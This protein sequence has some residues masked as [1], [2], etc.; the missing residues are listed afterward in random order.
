MIKEKKK[1][2]YSIKLI[3][4]RFCYKIFYFNYILNKTINNTS[5]FFFFFIF[6]FFFFIFFFIK[7][8]FFFFFKF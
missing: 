2:E 4:L 5:F 7:K 3:I 8:I 1:K 6:F